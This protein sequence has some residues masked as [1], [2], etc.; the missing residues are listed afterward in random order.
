MKDTHYMGNPC[1]RGHSGIRV[2][3]N[4]S[5]VECNKQKARKYWTKA[6]AKKKAA[7]HELELWEK[8]TNG[9]AALLVHLHDVVDNYLKL[10]DDHQAKWDT[11]CFTVLVFYD[12]LAIKKHLGNK[13]VN[14]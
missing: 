9:Q 11:Y 7:E 13:R 3:S 1:K 2:K 6:A 4:R 8:Q 14:K 12:L 5:C 10:G